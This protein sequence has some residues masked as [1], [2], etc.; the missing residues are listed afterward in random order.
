MKK[1]LILGDNPETG[2]LVKTANDMG[3]RTI[4]TGIHHNSLAKQIAWKA[5]DINA[6]DVDAME[7]LAKAENIEL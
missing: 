2:A 3:V 7:R 1:L 4:V 5:V 6:L